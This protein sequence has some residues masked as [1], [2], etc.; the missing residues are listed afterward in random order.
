MPEW[1]IGVAE[2]GCCLMGYRIRLRSIAVKRRSMGKQ[3]FLRKE[4]ALDIR[5]MKRGPEQPRL[6][7]KQS[8]NCQKLTV[9]IW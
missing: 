1:T 6:E 5:Q 7:K 8:V 9:P 2:D 3:R 4:S